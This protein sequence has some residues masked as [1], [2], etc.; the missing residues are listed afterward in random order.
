MNNVT[1][2]FIPLN[3]CGHLIVDETAGIK[4]TNNFST[5]KEASKWVKDNKLKICSILSN[6][7]NDKV[8]D[9]SGFEVRII[10]DNKIKKKIK[11]EW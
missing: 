10:K 8:K 9:F 2:I 5:I 6:T 3:K 7:Y 4:E 1:L 11:L